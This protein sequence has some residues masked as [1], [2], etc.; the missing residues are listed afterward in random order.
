MQIK[1]QLNT[2][3]VEMKC[4]VHDCNGSMVRTGIQTLG[5]PSQVNN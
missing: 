2:L 4:S 3:M 1:T 5:I